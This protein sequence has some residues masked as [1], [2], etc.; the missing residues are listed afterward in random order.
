M[1]LLP[2]AILR[3]A[4]REVD[5]AAGVLTIFFFEQI[6]M[7]QYLNCLA[8]PTLPA[9]GHSQMGPRG[10]TLVIHRYGVAKLCLGSNRVVLAETALTQADVAIEIRGVTFQG[11]FVICRSLVQPLLGL[12]HHCQV[13]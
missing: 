11:A 10:R 12:Q 4:D 13:E 3:E 2:S 6:G 5:E 8:I 9:E 1:R 7:Y